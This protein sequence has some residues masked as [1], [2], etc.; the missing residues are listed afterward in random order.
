MSHQIQNFVEERAITRLCHFTQSANLT[1]I[2]QQ[3]ILSRAALDKRGGPVRY[4]DPDRWDGHQTKVSCSI[5]YPNAWYFARARGERTLF[6]GWTVLLFSPRHLWRHGT[7]F[8]QG[9]AARN[10]G[11]DC[12]SGPEA[13]GALFNRSSRR[14]PSAPSDLQSEVLIRGPVPACD[15]LGLVVE[16]E[17]QA[18]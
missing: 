8:C 1:S 9:N 10:R 6:G 15:L 11:R 2:L 4:S 13:F 5:E 14:L 17:Q 7:L 16:S 12:R 3:G 18:R